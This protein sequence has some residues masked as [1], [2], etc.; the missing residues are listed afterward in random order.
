MNDTA[1]VFVA[2][3]TALASSAKGYGERALNG[4]PQ[5]GPEYFDC[6]GFVRAV[7]LASAPSLW[8]SNRGGED[9][10]TV[11]NFAYWWTALHLQAPQPYLGCPPLTADLLVF[12]AND[13]IGVADG[14]DNCISALDPARGIRSVPIGH[15]GLPLTYILR[16]GLAQAGPAPAPSPSPPPPPKPA[17]STY[18]VVAHDTLSLIGARLGVTWRAIYAAN[19]AAIGPNPNLIHA[20]LRLVIPG[21]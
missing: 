7:I 5:R 11:P 13:H 15:V 6:I 21:R 14:H 16:T 2:Y 12:G 4:L 20:G 9:S 18:T 1:T 17:P 8:P 3:A 19:A 10:W